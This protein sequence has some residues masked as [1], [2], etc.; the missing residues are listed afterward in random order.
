MHLPRSRAT[1]ALPAQRAVRAGEST[2]ACGCDPRSQEEAC[3]SSQRSQRVLVSQKCQREP[4]RASTPAQRQRW[5]FGPSGVLLALACLTSPCCTPLIVP[6][7]LSLFVGTPA[8]LWLT[9]HG[10]WI[11]GVLTGVSLLSAGLGWL[12]WMRSQGHLAGP[13]ARPKSSTKNPASGSRPSDQEA[14]V[15]SSE[16]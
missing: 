6:L 11:Y 9:Q 14:L 4:E 1:R 8:A 3:L 5:S 15:P 12:S 10:G 2:C 7:F 13:V 16:R